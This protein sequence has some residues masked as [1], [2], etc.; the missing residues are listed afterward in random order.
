MTE[1]GLFAY[2]PSEKH[3]KQ[4]AKKKKM[5]FLN[6]QFVTMPLNKG[7]Q[8]HCYDDT[9]T[10]STKTKT[11]IDSE[12]ELLVG[13]E[14]QGFDVN[15][16]K[17]NIKYYTTQQI[18]HG[19]RERELQTDLGCSTKALKAVVHS[20]IID[21]NLVTSDHIDIAEKIWGKD[22]PILKGTDRQHQ[23][24]AIIN[25]LI[26]LPPE[27]YEKHP[28][29]VLEIDIMYVNTLPMLTEI[30]TTI[31]YKN[32]EHMTCCT[33][34]EIHRA[35]KTFHRIYNKRGFHVKRID[36]DNEF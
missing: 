16:V 14:L 15:V 20:R 28:E 3:H 23:P 8:V 2:K 35:L 5:L 1:E 30:D 11:G 21:D 29:V 27:I 17:E 34:T 22:V 13:Y 19:K 6:T 10:L 26:Q 36:C 9:V 24:K 31:K 4:V 33:V 32:F 12:D 18:T 25:D 7:K